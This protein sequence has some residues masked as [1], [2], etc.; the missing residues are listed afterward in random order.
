MIAGRSR[1]STAEPSRSPTRTN[2][3]KQVEAYGGEDSDGARMFIRGLFPR[4]AESQFI[5]LDVVEQAQKNEPHVT[6]ND[7]L[8]FGVDVAPLR[9]GQQRDRHPQGA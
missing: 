6:L 1:Q 3:P 2:S 4:I 5:S 7:A 8:I 9:R